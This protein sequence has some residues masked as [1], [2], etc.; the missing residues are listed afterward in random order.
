LELPQS[1]QQFLLS[2]FC[3]LLPAVSASDV[4]MV[5]R[6]L[7][8]R[9]AAAGGSS[10]RQQ[11]RGQQQLWQMLHYSLAGSSRL[12][13]A[14]P[15]PAAMP[16]PASG[17]CVAE[18]HIM[19]Q[20]VCCAEQ[21]MHSMTA[22]ELCQCIWSAAWLGFTLSP[23]WSY[24][25]NH[26]LPQRMQQLGPGDVC[27]L[28]W[29]L[30]RLQGALM[31]KP[32]LHKGLLLHSQRLMLAGRFTARDLSGFIWSYAQVFALQPPPKPWLL[33]FCRASSVQVMSMTGRQLGVLLH[34]LVLLGAAA[35]PEQQLLD[36]ARLKLDLLSA[37]LAQPELG[38]IKA[39]I[40]Q[41]Q[42][43][44]MAAGTR[45]RMFGS[46][47]EGEVLLAQPIC[48]APS[49][50]EHLQVGGNHKLPQLVH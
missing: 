30:A 21:L 43:R 14:R 25:L 27:L 38:S 28:L 31:P 4:T 35:V 2:M 32:Q 9:Q 50:P 16:P 20:L 6:S 48:A 8:V 47:Q 34:G 18:Q 42:Q 29:S 15:F 36:A 46:L 17:R 23:D 41:L 33:V 39:S 45:S 19:Q 1:Q 37:V 5:L 10:S 44:R 3:S 12:L 13:H 24:A 22:V 11:R 7:A 40:V 49:K 26:T